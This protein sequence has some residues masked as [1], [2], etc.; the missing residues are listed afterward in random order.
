MVS[1][2]S[3]DLFPVRQAVPWQKVA[4]LVAAVVLNYLAVEKIIPY[5]GPQSLAQYLLFFLLG[6][7]LEPADAVH[8]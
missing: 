7:I 3:G 1:V 8:E 6:G 5:R 4:L 2:W